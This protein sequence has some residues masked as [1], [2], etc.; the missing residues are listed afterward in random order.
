L[1]SKEETNPDKRYS[2]QN[3]GQDLCI[4][5]FNEGGVEKRVSL[6]QL[7]ITKEELLVIMD[8]CDY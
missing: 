2:K 5:P 7:G 1:V 6:R 4:S 8:C 3:E